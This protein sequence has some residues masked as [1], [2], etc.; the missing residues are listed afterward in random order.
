M[1][2]N[3]GFVRL[4][5]GPRTLRKRTPVRTLVGQVRDTFSISPNT[6]AHMAQGRMDELEALHAA[7]FACV[8]KLPTLVPLQDAGSE[9]VGLSRAALE[10]AL[11]PLC[12]PMVLV[13]EPEDILAGLATMPADGEAWALRRARSWL[14]ANP[15]E[16]RKAKSAAAR[17]NIV[18][19][20]CQRPHG[21]PVSSVVDALLAMT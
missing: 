18:R 5:F 8:E 13:A 14:K 1:V 7:T 2:L 9:A 10:E 17:E 15:H 21:V 6:T 20:L 12:T 19:S 4:H 11:L 3:G 16:L